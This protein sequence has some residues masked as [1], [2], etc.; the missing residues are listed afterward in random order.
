MI[1]REDLLDLAYPYALEA[2][3]PADRD[4]VETRLATAPETLRAEFEQ[5]V[6]D[7][8]ETMAAWSSSVAVDPP[9]GL[10]D[11]VLTAI[12]ESSAVDEP[13]TAKVIPLRRRPR[14]QSLAAGVAA[15]V[16]LL[17]GSA[18][19]ANLMTGRTE[20]TVAQAVNSAPDRQIREVPSSGGGVLEVTFSRQ[21][22]AAVVHFK[23]PGIVPAG[24]AYQLWYIDGTPKSAGVVS[25]TSD[26]IT[27]GSL[28]SSSA[29]ALTIEPEGGSQQPTMDPIAVANL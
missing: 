23:S 5:T 16:A 2:L 19:V 13:T 17:F 10:R 25:D 1:E 3:E 4:A 6:K 28:G 22:D 24:R 18:V 21:L 27:V 29:L 26:E 7:I 20:I 14:W 11:R 8:R 12:D 15:V 9:A